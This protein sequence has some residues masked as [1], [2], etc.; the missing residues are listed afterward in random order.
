MWRLQMISHRDLVRNGGWWRG[1]STEANLPTAAPLLLDREVGATRGLKLCCVLEQ[2]LHIITF[3]FCK[4]S[5]TVFHLLVKWDSGVWRWGDYQ[6][7]LPWLCL[8]P[9]PAMVEII[10]RGWLGTTFAVSRSKKMLCVRSCAWAAA[11]YLVDGLWF[12]TVK[13]NAS[14][15]PTGRQSTGGGLQRFASYSTDFMNC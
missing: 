12:I 13:A 6:F 1:C 2:V 8:K 14:Q 5:S 7:L 15:G 3:W 10:H 9:T 4:E 11:V